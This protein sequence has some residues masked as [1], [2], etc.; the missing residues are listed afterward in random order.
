MRVGPVIDY[1]MPEEKEFDP[2][3]SKQMDALLAKRYDEK[4]QAAVDYGGF[5]QPSPMPDAVPPVPKMNPQHARSWT[6]RSI[7]SGL[8][9]EVEGETWKPDTKGILTSPFGINTRDHAKLLEELRIQ[10]NVPKIKDIPK[11]SLKEA[12]LDIFSR[13]GNEY[14]VGNRGITPTEWRTLSGEGQFVVTSATFNTGNPYPNLTRALIKYESNPTLANLSAAVK[15]TWRGG[16]KN[17]QKGADNRAV[18]DLIAG[19]FIDLSKPEH[20]KILKKHL[21]R[22]SLKSR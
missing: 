21:K 14:A 10:K 5:E 2:E 7:M 15:Q 18:K 1:V 17:A 12:A 22:Y 3:A 6:S 19:G 8:I 11:E 20:I 9:G 4:K 13:M 16:G